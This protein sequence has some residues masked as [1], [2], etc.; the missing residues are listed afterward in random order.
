VRSDRTLKK[1]ITVDISRTLG[2]ALEA[3]LQLAKLEGQ[4]PVP[5]RLLAG[6][7]GMPRRFLLQILRLLVD[8]GIVRSTR[9]VIGGYTLT[10]KADQISLL[11]LVEAIYGP[12]VGDTSSPDVPTSARA[13]LHAIC[14]E[15][16]A[17]TRC[18]LASTSLAQLLASAST[19][20]TPQG[21]PAPILLTLVPTFTDAQLILQP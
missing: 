19:S 18:R 4:G 2:Y 6:A 16:A 5:C 21:T 14:E 12:I 1:G 7:G 20:T 11:E 15:V 9:G 17:A 8:R 3:T 10:R 13:A